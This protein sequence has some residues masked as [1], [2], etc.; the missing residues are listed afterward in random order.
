MS[1]LFLRNLL[2]VIGKRDTIIHTYRHIHC[3]VLTFLQTKSPVPYTNSI[4]VSPYDPMVIDCSVASKLQG[5]VP[6]YDQIVGELHTHTLE[7]FLCIPLPGRAPGM[8]FFF[9][10][11]FIDTS[12]YTSRSSSTSISGTVDS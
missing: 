9:F 8:Y 1:M 5:Y 11:I 12:Q 10:L 2:H 7:Y 4:V 3:V 6:Y